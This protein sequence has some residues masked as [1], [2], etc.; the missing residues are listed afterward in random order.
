MTFLNR[1]RP[2]FLL[3]AALPA[4]AAV[5]LLGPIDWRGGVLLILYGSW[6]GEI[7][8]RINPRPDLPEDPQPWLPW[9]RLGAGEKLEYLLPTLLMI[10]L[11][12]LLTTAIAL[13]GGTGI[14]HWLTLAGGLVGIAAGAW[15]LRRRWLGRWGAVDSE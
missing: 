2:Y 15:E 7:H 8:G 6:I 14:K 12:V 3:I 10:G 13:A 4:V 1:F 9:N 5:H 11:G